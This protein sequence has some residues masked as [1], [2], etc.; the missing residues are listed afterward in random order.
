MRFLVVCPAS[1]EASAAIDGPV[2][3]GNERNLGGR[4]ARRANGVVHL[5]LAGALGLT[6]VPARL[7]TDGLVLEAFFGIEFLLT[8][9]EYEF[10]AA[11]L[12]YQCLVLEHVLSLIHI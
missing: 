5:T 12:A 1:L 11:I 3:L 8:G 4:A 7:A 9:R 2:V 6:S 10:S